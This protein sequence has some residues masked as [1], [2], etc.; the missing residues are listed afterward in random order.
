MKRPRATPPTSSGTE[1]REEGSFLS[2]W[3]RRKQIAR[4]GVD[5]DHVDRARDEAAGRAPGQTIEARH[6]GTEM[7]ATDGAE[8]DGELTDADMP[9]LHSIDETTDMSGFFSGKVTDAV[10]RAALRKFFHSP[11]FN[12][13][14]GLDDYA[15][16]FTSFAPLGD[17]ITSDMR[18]RMEVEAERARAAL[19]ADRAGDAEDGGPQSG[20]TGESGDVHA[21][22]AETGGDP[23][24]ATADP[25]GTAPP[26]SGEGAGESAA[27]I[28]GAPDG[29]PSP[30]TVARAA[31]PGARP[32]K[33]RRRDQDPT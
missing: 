1:A 22:D 9:P 20:D 4:S 19:E 24:S 11:A 25:P 32:G 31:G 23:E 33:L 21:A 2:R 10:K 17:I 13:V 15:E 30:M 12:V 14:D 7:S 16:D 28:P 26:K 3:A 29:E 18:H 27:A 5:P 6:A 8:P